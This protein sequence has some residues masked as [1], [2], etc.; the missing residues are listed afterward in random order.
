M[1]EM[2]KK[3]YGSSPKMERDEES[4]KMAVKKKVATKEDDKKEGED[5]DGSGQSLPVTVRHQMERADMHNTMER[6]HAMTDHAKITDKKDMHERHSKMMSDLI[7]R[8][9]KEMGKKE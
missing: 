3:M 4:G 1:G 9:E 7:R 6:E 8:H 5:K 2:A